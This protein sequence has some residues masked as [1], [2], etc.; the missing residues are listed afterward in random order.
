V[1]QIDICIPSWERYELTLESFSDVYEDER[2]ANIIIVDDCSNLELFNKLKSVCDCLT[3]VKL[4]RNINNQ[5]CYTNKMV[6][7][8]Y[9]QNEYVILFD[10]DNR[11]NKQ[12]IDKIYEEEWFEK[13]I[14]APVF[15]RPTFDYRQFGDKVINKE[16]VRFIIDEPMF[17]TSLNTMN[18]FINKKRYLETFDKDFNPITADSIYINYIWLKN[19]GEIKFVKGMEYDHLVHEQSHYVNNISRTPNN[20]NEII[21][22]NI[23]N[24]K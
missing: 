12:Y 8:S 1:K 14:L 17:T 2:I 15:A 11:L 20:L 4:Y 9:A 24:L 5:D 22:E 23:R 6:S 19:G 3:K 10:S 18:Y 13:R 7:V 21:V 16:N